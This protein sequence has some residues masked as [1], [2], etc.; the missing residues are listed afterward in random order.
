M[1]EELRRRTY[2]VHEAAKLTGISV[3]NYYKLA[4]QGKVPARHIGERR[5]VVP[6]VQLEQWLATSDKY[7]GDGHAK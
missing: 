7:K 1:S 4:K 6:K 5:I 2:S 3:P